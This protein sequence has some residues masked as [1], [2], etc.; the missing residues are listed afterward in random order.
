MTWS[1]RATWFSSAMDFDNNDGDDD[2]DDDGIKDVASANPGT[3]ASVGDVAGVELDGVPCT[4][5]KEKEKQP[6]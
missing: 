6:K 2:D 3:D 4:S 5:K 1:S